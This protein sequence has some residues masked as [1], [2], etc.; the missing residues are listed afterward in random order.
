MIS[1]IRIICNYRIEL[2]TFR[3]VYIS[4]IAHF[5]T[6]FMRPYFCESTI[7]TVRSFSIFFLS[8]ILYF[9]CRV[10]IGTAISSIS[11]VDIFTYGGDVKILIR[12]KKRHKVIICRSPF[13][14]M[15]VFVHKRLCPSFVLEVIGGNIDIIVHNTAVIP[16][17]RIRSKYGNADV[18][19]G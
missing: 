6:R 10:N 8:I 12:R 3:I 4:H 16:R 14:K 1:I 19:A 15:S 5:R 13:G 11:S 17:R 9:A 18:N 7:L 2:P